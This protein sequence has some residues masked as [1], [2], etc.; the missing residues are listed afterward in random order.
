MKANN[1]P[2][3]LYSIDETNVIYYLGT[4]YRVPQSAGEISLEM[5]LN[6]EVENIKGVT[7]KVSDYKPETSQSH[8]Q[9]NQ[10]DLSYS[11]LKARTIEFPGNHE[12]FD[13]VGSCGTHPQFRH[14]SC[15]PKG[16]QIK[17]SE[18]GTPIYKTA[19]LEIKWKFFSIIWTKYTTDSR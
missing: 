4:E 16:Y 1:G 10:I 6:K 2:L 19:D 9:A 14:L 18:S 7:F 15:P 13:Q 12:L 3:F 5:W 8:F 17:P 11:D